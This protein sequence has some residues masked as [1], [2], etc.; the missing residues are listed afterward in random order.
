MTDIPSSIDW[1]V[2]MKVVRVA[3]FQRQI[4]G[5]KYPLVGGVYTI[6]EIFVSP[7]GKV[8]ILLQEVRNPSE[9]SNMVIREYGFDAEK[10]RPVQKHKTS[11]EIFNRILLNPRIRIS[12]DA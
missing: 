4:P 8:I 10:F 9:P 1:H 11:I 2:G 7:L 3:E 12:E 5:H 6:R